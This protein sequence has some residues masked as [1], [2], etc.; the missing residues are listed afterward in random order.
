MKADLTLVKSYGTALFEASKSKGVLETVAEHADVLKD[1]VAKEEKFLT[2]LHAPNIAREDKESLFIKVFGEKIHSMLIYFVRML[3]RR[4]RL[5]LFL[6]ALD[7]F[8]ELYLA[9]K[10]F[11]RGEL[12][13]AVALS[14]DQKKLLTESLNGFTGKNL[15]IDFKVDPTL[16]G[17]LRFLS[18]DLLID[19]TLQ[20]SIDRLAHNMMA[21]KVY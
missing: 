21:T 1:L 20:A 17:G 13:S 2:F 19:N 4:G 8:H 18:G 16:I 7:H 6:P 15:Q 5:A 3:I 12:V 11:A 10:G 9:E 14:E